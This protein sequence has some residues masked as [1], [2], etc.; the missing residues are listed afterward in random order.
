MKIN[1]DKSYFFMF[2]GK[3]ANIK[4]GLSIIN[5]S[6]QEKL[7]GII[8]DMTLNFKEYIRSICKRTSQKV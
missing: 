1:D 8:Q 4:I 2:G 3:E 7:L 5:E 6:Q